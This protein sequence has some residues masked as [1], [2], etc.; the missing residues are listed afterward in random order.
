MAEQSERGG[1]WAGLEHG[2]GTREEPPASGRRSSQASPRALVSSERWVL[3]GQ[4]M[5]TL[6]SASQHICLHPHV[7]TRRGAPA[8]AVS[9]PAE[10]CPS[11]AA[12][13][14]LWVLI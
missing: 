3:E 12:G 4:H 10:L 6:E 2:E 1:G 5:C 7:R 14:G 8:A 9:G 11:L 13:P